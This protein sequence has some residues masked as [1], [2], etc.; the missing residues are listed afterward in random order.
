M[1]QNQKHTGRRKQNDTAV[2]RAAIVSAV[3]LFL[4]CA[5]VLWERYG[6][7]WKR[8]SELITVTTEPVPAEYAAPAMQEGSVIMIDYPSKDYLTGEQIT[9]PA[10]VYL[11]YGYDESTQYDVLY[12]MHGWMMR[13]QDYLQE[14]SGIRQLFDHLIE[15]GRTEPFITVCLTFDRDN[16]PQ[17]YERSV[18]E[19]AMFQYELREYVMPYVESEFSTYAENTSVRGLRASRDHRAFGGFSMG[20]VTAW[21]QFIINL[22][23]I[24]DFIPMSCDSWIRGANGGL[25]KPEM[26]VHSLV[27]AVHDQRYHLDDYFIYACAGKGDP[28]FKN[29]DTQVQEMKRR[30]EFSAE[31]MIYGIKEDG[32]HDMN[33]VREYLYNALPYVF[34]KQNKIRNRCAS[35]R[36]RDQRYPQAVRVFL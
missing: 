3:M 12:L 5:L 32:L 36:P 10:V 17:S 35:E 34:P 9:K 1:K 33:T 6:S 21:H 29:I 13:A 14:S 25:L 22:D 16:E 8:S 19:L 7:Y 23:L 27:T 11:P 20:A 4:L 31:N 28:M 2:I 18:E 15:D 30:Q 24:H 26:T